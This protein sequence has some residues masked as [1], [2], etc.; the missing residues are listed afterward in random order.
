M[1]VRPQKWCPS[2]RPFELDG[3]P[4][5][6]RLLLLGAY[7]A[8]NVEAHLGLHIF[9]CTVRPYRDVQTSLRLLF[10]AKLDS[11]VDQCLT[12]NTPIVLVEF[13]ASTG[14]ERAS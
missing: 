10:Y 13:I 5:S 3:S 6:L 8:G 14:T 12:Y 9:F 4:L 2:K 1:L 7:D 11:V